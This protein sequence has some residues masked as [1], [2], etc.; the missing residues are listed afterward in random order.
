MINWYICNT[1]FY[2]YSL[3]WL[4][5]GVLT[6]FEKDGSLRSEVIAVLVSILLSYSIFDALNTVWMKAVQQKEGGTKML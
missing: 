1:V 2:W 6:T 3:E 4:M 5:L